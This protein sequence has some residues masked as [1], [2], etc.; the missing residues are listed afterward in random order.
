MLSNLTLLGDE[1][2]LSSGSSGMVVGIKGSEKG[3]STDAV[4]VTVSLASLTGAL[5]DTSSEVLRLRF[6][7]RVFFLRP[8]CDLEFLPE[9][10]DRPVVAECKLTIDGRE[11]DM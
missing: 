10:S 6:T 2:M 3:A 11:G 7:T 9:P 8:A 5:A 4:S 1:G